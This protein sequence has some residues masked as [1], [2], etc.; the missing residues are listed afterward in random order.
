MKT[1]KKTGGRGRIVADYFTFNRAEQ[2]GIMVLMIILLGLIITNAVIPSESFQR[3]ID[4]KSIGKD[5]DAFE[6]AWKKAELDDSLERVMNRYGKRN[7]TKMAPFDTLYKTRLPAK[8]AFTVELN[9]ADT[10]ELQRLRGIGPSFARRI[11]SYRSRLGGF[12]AKEQ[13]MEVF[14]MDTARYEQITAYIRVCKDSLKPIDLNKV[15]FKALLKHPYFPFE[16]TKNIML[17]R[18]KNKTFKSLEELLKIPGINDSLY[19]RMKVYL[20]LGR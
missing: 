11:V 18:Q 1:V 14:G 16:V 17:Y 12:I 10:F 5:V 4:F 3:Q 7:L 15:T 8:P 20:S 19:S 13:L 2:R 9:A 6:K